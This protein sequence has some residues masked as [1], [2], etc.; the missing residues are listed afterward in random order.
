MVAKGDDDKPTEVPALQLETRDDVRRFMESI[1][2]RELK[3]AFKYEL[4]NA[5]TTMEIHENLSLLEK[6]RCSFASDWETH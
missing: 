1:K 4:N 6:E 2:R 3:G 5:K